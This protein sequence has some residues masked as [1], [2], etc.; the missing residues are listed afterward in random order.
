LHTQ[1][2]AILTFYLL[3]RMLGERAER[4]RRVNVVL[5]SGAAVPDLA[6]FVFFVWYTLF[7]PTSQRVLWSE[8]AFRD[9]WQFVFS[10][11][12]SLPLWA[13]ASV[14]FLLLKMHR[15]A[16]FCLAALLSAVEDFFVHH[17]DGHAHFFPFSDYRF[18]SPVSYWDPAHYGWYAFATEVIV[19]LAAS[20]WTYRRLETRWGKW[21]L[22]LAVVSLMAT[23]SFWA[24]LFSFF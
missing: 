12:H 23:H 8:Y 2:H 15:A 9:E 20:V 14:A 7:E 13:I 24:V 16:L 5:F 6:I 3:R 4:I 10:M 21:L 18:E 11:F 22:I 19:V 17:D 1:S